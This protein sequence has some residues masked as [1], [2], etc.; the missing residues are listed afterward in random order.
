MNEPTPSWAVTAAVRTECIICL[1]KSSEQK[2]HEYLQSEDTQLEPLGLGLRFGHLR[3]LVQVIWVRE[4]LEQLSSHIRGFTGKI[5]IMKCE[6]LC[7]CDSSHLSVNT[8]LLFR[9]LGNMIQ[10]HALDALPDHLGW[11]RGQA[12]L[13]PA[14][15]HLL[16]HLLVI[17]CAACALYQLNTNTHRHNHAVM[18]DSEVIMPCTNIDHSAHRQITSASWNFTLSKLVFAYFTNCW[19]H[20]NVLYFLQARQQFISEHTEIYLLENFSVQSAF[21]CSHFVCLLQ[22]DVSW[23]DSYHRV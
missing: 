13:L 6:V 15:S 9:C 18:H 16:L 17:G 3:L 5:R 4:G 11:T 8:F 20:S 22:S 7:I 2:C 23:Y 1:F 21:C 10:H 19:Q 12:Q 14:L